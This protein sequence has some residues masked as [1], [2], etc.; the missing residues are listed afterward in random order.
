MKSNSKILIFSSSADKYFDAIKKR[1]PNSELYAAKS[2]KEI[3]LDPADVSVLLAWMIRPELLRQMTSLKWIQSIGAGVDPFFREAEALEDI[4]VT[5]SVAN[6]PRLMAQYA[7]GVVLGDNI[8]FEKHREN[9]A[10]K[11]W[12]WEPFS[13][14][15]GK[16]AVVIGTGNIGGEIARSLK[17]F[18]LQVIGV[19]RSGRS[20]EGFD[21]IYPM[22]KLDDALPQADYLI[23]VVPLTPQTKG[24]IDIGRIRKMK[25]SALLCNIA[26]GAV[27]VE[28]DLI[29]ALDQGM[30][31]RAVLD[32]FEKEPLPNDSPLWEHPRATV[33]PHIAGISDVELVAE[34]F[35]ENYQRFIRGETLLNIVDKKRQY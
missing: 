21:L 18:K 14:V 1:L 4:V 3:P 25:S 28:R 26:R 9:Q 13:D 5:R 15:N 32:V 34:E 29:N 24:M 35:A 12:A 6:L 27:I 33:T 17:F 30:I 19:N 8:G 11:N 2:S 20:V 16:T 31:R 23:V 7:A 22:E 10:A